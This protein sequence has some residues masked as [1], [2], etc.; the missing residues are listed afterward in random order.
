[1]PWQAARHTARLRTCD[2]AALAWSDIAIRARPGSTLI[3][4]LILVAHKYSKSEVVSVPSQSANRLANSYLRSLSYTEN[5]AV[6]KSILD[7]I[8]SCLTMTMNR[9]TGAG[10]A[11]GDGA[12]HA[13]CFNRRV[14]NP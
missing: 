10:F 11:R 5:Y 14:G 7:T 6:E 1:V 13:R 3:I 12:R 8:F 2:A 4:P 9:N